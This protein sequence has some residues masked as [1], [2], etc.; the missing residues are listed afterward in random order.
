[1]FN[2]CFSIIE[3]KKMHF[4]FNIFQKTT[5]LHN[6]WQIAFWLHENK[7]KF[8][9]FFVILQLSKPAFSYKFDFE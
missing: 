5:N 9:S 7:V 4:I 3:G 6:F 2:R 8:F 1:M